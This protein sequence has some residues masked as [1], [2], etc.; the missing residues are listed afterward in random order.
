[1]RARVR[2]QCFLHNLIIIAAVAH[3]SK[4]GRRALLPHH[5]ICDHHNPTTQQKKIYEIWHTKCLKLTLKIRGGE[6]IKLD[7]IP[8]I[9][10]IEP[11][12]PLITIE[13]LLLHSCC[14][15]FS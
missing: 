7:K 2:R 9:T 15:G 11:T 6:K 5:R 1:M 3:S 12:T 13:V 10:L 8:H 14:G 4:T